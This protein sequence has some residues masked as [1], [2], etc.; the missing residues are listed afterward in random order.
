VNIAL[1]DSGAANFLEEW[2]KV[3]KRANRFERVRLVAEYTAGQ[4]EQQS[5]FDLHER[6]SLA[7]ELQSQVAVV[8]SRTARRIGKRD[9]EVEDR[10][11]VSRLGEGWGGTHGCPL[12]AWPS[13]KKSSNPTPCGQ[14]F[15]QNALSSTAIAA[16]N[17][18]LGVARR[19]LGGQGL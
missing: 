12:L 17:R 8:G 11:E 5:G 1:V 3:A 14:R 18:G 10:F 13:P 15:H 2:D 7:V 4:A 16:G 19:L 6:Q 9:I